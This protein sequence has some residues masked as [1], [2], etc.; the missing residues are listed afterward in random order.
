MY[1]AGRVHPQTALVRLPMILPPEN[2][3]HMRGPLAEVM[4]K[5]L[6]LERDG[7]I[8]HAALYPTQPWLDTDSMASAVCVVT[9]GDAAAAQRVA[10]MLAEMFWSRRSEFVTELVPPDEAIRRVLAQETG[11]VV[12]CDSADATSSGSTGDSTAILQALV[13]AGEFE[14]IALVNIV[15]AEVVEQAIA[16][17]IG[18]TLTVSVGGKIAPG[19]FA[20]VSFTGY[21]KTISDGSFRFKGPAMR[22][23]VQHRGRTVVLY[24]G[25]IHLVVMERPVTQWDPELYRSLGEEPGDAR[26]VQVKSPMA[27]RAAYESITENVVVIAAPGAATPQLDSLPWKRVPRPIYPL[28]LDVRWP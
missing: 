16:S 28:D 14:P 10:Q 22:G 12:F 6:E 21:V 23:M 26:I 8:E 25:G 20:P 24:S 1:L 4:D 7:T 15:D 5:A 18:S 17:G 9:N 11:T 19:Y 13:D 3:S 2:S 27:F